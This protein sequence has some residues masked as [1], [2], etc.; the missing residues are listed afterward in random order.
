M[1]AIFCTI[2]LLVSSYSENYTLLTRIGE[3]MDNIKSRIRNF[4]NSD[5]QYQDRF[6]KY[7]TDT[8]YKRYKIRRSRGQ[9]GDG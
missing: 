3:S 6:S 5:Y 7:D 8:D 2:F 9:L 4:M 1:I